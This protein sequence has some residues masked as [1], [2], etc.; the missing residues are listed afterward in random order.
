MIVPSNLEPHLTAFDV[1]NPRPLAETPRAHL[2]RVDSVNGP[3][4]LK[5][6]T[7]RG[8]SAG[9]LTGAEALRLWNGE[10]VVQLIGLTNNALLMEW[11]PGP[12][13]GEMARSG[14]DNEA[15]NL[16]AEISLKLRRP[17]STGFCALADHYDAALT[18]AD[19]ST[20]PPSYRDAFRR[21]Q[22]L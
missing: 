6:L 3:A 21:A 22:S 12:S 1:Q 9:E 7:A 16:I 2:W 10:G 20:F 17:A 19:I 4:V 14:L 15:A 5:V 13:M 8:V 18:R 11:L